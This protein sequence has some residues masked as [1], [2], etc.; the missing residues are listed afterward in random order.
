VYSEGCSIRLATRVAETV[1]WLESRRAPPHTFKFSPWP[2]SCRRV[3]P[4]IGAMGA[5]L[6]FR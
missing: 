2:Q 1:R 3:V 6:A 4:E 5:A